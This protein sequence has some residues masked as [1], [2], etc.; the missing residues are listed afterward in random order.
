M[1]VIPNRDHRM[2]QHIDVWDHIQECSRKGVCCVWGCDKLA[3]VNDHR[4]AP[5]VVTDFS[6]PFCTE[7]QQ[8]YL[9]TNEAVKEGYEADES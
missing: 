7:H 2:P 5:G 3:D 8:G 9:R 1:E 6:V 4:L